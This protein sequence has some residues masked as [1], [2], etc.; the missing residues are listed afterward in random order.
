M[1]GAGPLALC[2]VWAAPVAA[3]VAVKL[4]PT[5]RD[6]CAERIDQAAGAFGLPPRA[7][8]ELIPLVDEAGRPNPV[9]YV[10]YALTPLSDGR[11]QLF[12][13]TGNDAQ[14]WPDRG[15]TVTASRRGR[16]WFRRLGGRFAKLETS[17]DAYVAPFKAALDDCLTMG[18]PK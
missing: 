1:R 7:R 10:D 2:L 12:V 6:R 18:E 8:R 16:T 3:D 9:E 15:W 13:S 14:R 11:E 5:W 17:R 4:P